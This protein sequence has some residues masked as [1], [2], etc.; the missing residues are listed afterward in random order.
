[1]KLEK[2]LLSMDMVLEMG[3]SV[4]SLGGTTTAT[5]VG[6]GSFCVVPTPNKGK[7]SYLSS[8]SMWTSGITGGKGPGGTAGGGG[9]QGQRLMTPPARSG[10]RSKANHV[11]SFLGGIK[12]TET[13]SLDKVP[14]RPQHGV[15]IMPGN[16]AAG[17]D[18]SWWGG[19]QGSLL[20]SSAISVAAAGNAHQRPAAPSN[21]DQDTAGSA[22]PR[23]Q[24]Q[25]AST[26]TKQL[27]QLMDSLNRLGNENAHLMRQVEAASGARAEA[28][29]AKDMMARF[30]IEYRQKF[31][32]VKEALKRY[33]LHQQQTQGS[34]VDGAS[35][36]GNLVVNR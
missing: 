23:Q 19:G 10:L 27:M 35:D 30:K 1:M 29:A 7:A 33:P 24:Q 2:E 12:P 9:A 6:Q 26:N 15:Q 34:S 25:H 28:K 31:G 8:S 32:K 20:A 3:N 14:H 13:N 18:Q 16:A 4:A 36:A 5:G 17:L 11:Q 22:G 21:N